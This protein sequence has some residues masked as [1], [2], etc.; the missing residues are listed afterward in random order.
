MI[1]DIQDW[2]H[3]TLIL[4][5]NSCTKFLIRMIVVLSS[6]NLGVLISSLGYRDLVQYPLASRLNFALHVYRRLEKFVKETLTSINFPNL[7][8]T[9]S[10]SLSQINIIIFNLTYC[11]SNLMKF[12]VYLQAH[13]IINK[14]LLS[15]KNY[16]YWSVP[17]LMLSIWWF[18]YGYLPLLLVLFN[19]LL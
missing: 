8:S 10:L 16:I 17:S 19:F 13:D 9:F 2:I 1:V 6:L 15:S 18:V 4:E 12:C 7:Q 11:F 14:H 3:S 5:S